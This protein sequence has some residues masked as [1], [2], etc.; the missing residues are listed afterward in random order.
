MMQRYERVLKKGNR[1]RIKLL[2]RSLAANDGQQSHGEASADEPPP[3]RRDSHTIRASRTI[4][5]GSRTIHQGDSIQY[6]PPEFT[7]DEATDDDGDDDDGWALAA[8]EALDAT[9]VFKHGDAPIA[10][11]SVPSDNLRKL[12][13][14]LLIIAPLGPQ[15]SLSTYAD[16]LVGDQLE[17]LR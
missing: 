1:D 8:L 6:H 2:F 4:R 3:I 5:R 11:V 15:E 16:R 12:I 7:I 14:L 9:E 13:V 10:E 17:G